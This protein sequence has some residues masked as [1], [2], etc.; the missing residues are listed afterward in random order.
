[1]LW[2]LEN[3]KKLRL[4]T[5]AQLKELPKGTKLYDITGDGPYVVGEDH[6][7]GDTRNGLLAFGTFVKNET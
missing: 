6:I 3:G 2:T 7:D 5:P 4:I 1:M